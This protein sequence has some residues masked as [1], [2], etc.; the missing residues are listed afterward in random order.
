MFD[1]DGRIQVDL[2]QR[3]HEGLSRR[4]FALG[5]V[6][7]YLRE[8]SGLQLASIELDG[9]AGVGV[10][11]AQIEGQI[12]DQYFLVRDLG[13]PGRY[14]VARVTAAAEDATRA[15]NLAGDILATMEGME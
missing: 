1:P 2:D 11:G 3:L 6:Q 7:P 5:C 14:L 10:R 9:I 4:E 12:L 13:R 8:Q 15:L